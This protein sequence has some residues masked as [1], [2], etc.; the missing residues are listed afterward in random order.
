MGSI[1]AD[2]VIDI[3]CHE[4]CLDCHIHVSNNASKFFKH[5]Q[6]CRGKTP[7]RKQYITSVKR[8]FRARSDNRLLE[9]LRDVP[10]ALRMFSY[11]GKT[12]DTTRN[13]TLEAPVYEAPESNNQ[14]RL[15]KRRSGQHPGHQHATLPPPGESFGISRA[16]SSACSVEIAQT[17][18]TNNQLGSDTLAANPESTAS[19]LGANFISPSHNEQLSIEMS[20]TA[21][22]R[23]VPVE[24]ATMRSEILAYMLSKLPGQHEYIE[25]YV[26]ELTPQRAQDLK[27]TIF[28]DIGLPCH[29]V[30]NAFKD[31]WHCLEA[32][33]AFR[34]EKQL[35]V[36]RSTCM[37]VDV[38][39]CGDWE[40]K[41]KVDRHQG[42][43]LVIK[44]RMLIH[45]DP[46]VSRWICNNN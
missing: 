44:Y 22:T 18:R 29:N 11:D 19:I 5:A 38:D 32:S 41:V 10:N 2:A 3:S 26:R 9:L 12:T 27:S 25:R 43:R 39:P 13:R 17:D 1:Y 37:S 14:E 31:L 23:Q 7:E 21:A 46:P 6:K 34:M 30:E 20:T 15:S 24:E 42:L 40:V 45:A 33:Q 28:D 8:S 35:E 4:M 36:P 16:E